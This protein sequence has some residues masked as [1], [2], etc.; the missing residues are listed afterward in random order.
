VR[1]RYSIKTQ[2]TIDVGSLARQFEV[3]NTGDVPCQSH[4]PCS[5]DGKWK[6]ASS[7]LSLDA[8]KGNEFRNI[9]ASC[10]AGPCPFTKFDP[11][12]LSRPSRKI[13]ITVLNWS[14]TAS[15]L[16]EAEVTR[17]MTTEMVR[18]SYPFV[19]GETITFALPAAAEG[20]SILADV[21]AQEIVFPLGPNL[22]LSWATCT[23]EVAPGGN[24]LYRCELKPGFLIQ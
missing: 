18:H 9:R 23:V 8:Q 11:T 17:T 13:D 20:P 10:I 24:K 3:V 15:F 19:T 12:D 2:T 5:P 4:K 7:T 21:N 16:V 14:D 1:L 22:I 6:A